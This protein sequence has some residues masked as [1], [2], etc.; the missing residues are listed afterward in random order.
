MCASKLRIAINKEIPGYCD[1]KNLQKM[2]DVLAIK[3]PQI[4][5]IVDAYVQKDLNIKSLSSKSTDLENKEYFEKLSL[6]YGDNECVDV[7]LATNMISVGLDVSRLALMVI[8]GQPLT[9]AEYIQA[10]SRVGRGD[11]PGIVFTN[12]YKTQARSISHYENFKAYHNSFY[13][14]VEPT[15]ITPFTYQARLR[16]LHASL[17]IALRFANVGLLDNKDAKNFD[18][19]MMCLG[20]L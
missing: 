15:S 12:Y 8:M 11:T 14:Y 16:A 6:S 4:K 13:K 2:Q 9:T 7:A 5:S 3:D 20:I 10:S 19:N 17:I 18:I 1:D